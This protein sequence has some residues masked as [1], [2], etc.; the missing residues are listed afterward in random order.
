MA[1][2]IG[3]KYFAKSGFNITAAH[4]DSPCLKLKPVSKVVK[5]DFREV[6][7]QLYG[8]GLWHTWF[9]RD[10][11][12]SGLVMVRSKDT[13][14]ARV[15]NITKPLLRI[16]SLAIHLDRGANESFTFNNENHL[17]P[18]ICTETKGVKKTT[19]EYNSHHP[20]LVDLL[21]QELKCEPKDIVEVDLS[22][23]DAQ[24]SCL[25]G[26]RQEFILSGRLDN[27]MMSWCCLDSII[28]ASKQLDDE[29]HTNLC[30]LFDHEEVGSTSTTGAQSTVMESTMRRIATSFSNQDYVDLS[31]PIRK[32]F[33][34]SCDMA[35]GVHP[36]YAEKHESN[37][38]P[39]IH[40]GPVIKTN[41]NL[42]YATS[43]ESTLIT[44][45]LARITNVP[46]QEFV[47]RN[48]STCG[49]TIGPGLAAKLGMRCVDLG[50]AQLAM[51]SIREMAGNDDLVHTTKLLVSFYKNFSRME[52]NFIVD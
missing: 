33:L 27:L 24:D 46:V 32:S 8:G 34:F 21:A 15:V 41:A 42:R 38:R 39:K 40:S 3:K 7:V 29:T 20:E 2:S 51:H 35:H 49:S 52:K 10:L 50:I 17:I 48:D 26:S 16:P 28:E 47:I 1:F 43:I 9:D 36:N 19:P 30:V 5:S 31:I 4:T 12:V 14:Q 22:L 25:G 18:I 13:I 11:G 37:H 44:K 6:G 45:E 23:C